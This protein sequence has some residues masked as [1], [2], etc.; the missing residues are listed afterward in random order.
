MSMAPK[1]LAAPLSFI[2]TPNRVALVQ[3]QWRID[4]R[5][6]NGTLKARSV[7]RIETAV[8]GVG[9]NVRRPCGLS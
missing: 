3:F 9:W 7:T 8:V 5:P 4:E 2:T 1:I 6:M